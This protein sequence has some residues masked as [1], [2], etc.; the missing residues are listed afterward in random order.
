MNAC[1]AVFACCLLAAAPAV[2]A[3]QTNDQ[4]AP[5]AEDPQGLLDLLVEVGDPAQ[6]FDEPE[7]TG[8]DLDEAASEPRNARVQPR[9][10]VVALDSSG[11]MAAR[12]GGELK[13]DAARAAVAD[14]LAG[15]PDNV[16]VGL[17]AFGHHGDNTEQGRAV[18][19]AGV[20]RLM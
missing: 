6:C 20:V 18:S 9:R 4:I 16:E 7:L 17:V 12:A 11:S 1:R 5:V 3:A 8:V 15:L 13:M 14:F 10:V 19:C 2:A